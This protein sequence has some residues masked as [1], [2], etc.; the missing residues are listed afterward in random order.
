MGHGGSCSS[1]MTG[2]LSLGERQ[3]EA[4]GRPESGEGEFNLGAPLSGQ[5]RKFQGQYTLMSTCMTQDTN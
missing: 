4:D 3:Q 1:E 2:Q 5:S